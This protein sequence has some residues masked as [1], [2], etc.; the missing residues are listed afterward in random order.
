MNPELWK[1]K[2]GI[3]VGIQSPPPRRSSSTLLSGAGTVAAAEASETKVY[4]AA[5]FWPPMK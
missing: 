1:L 3:A 5:R 2:R 4:R